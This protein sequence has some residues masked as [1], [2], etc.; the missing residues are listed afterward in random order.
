MNNDNNYR[1]HINGLKVCL[2]YGG[3]IEKM[4]S[5][6]EKAI[7]NITYFNRV[8]EGNA[9]YELQS[10]CTGHFWAIIPVE[11]NRKGIYY[12]LLHKYREQDCY[13]L[14]T[15]CNSVLDA[16]LE[17][18]SHDDY[19]MKRNSGFFEKVWKQYKEME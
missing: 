7:M 8:H 11:L 9:I 4:F 13:H 5:D 19:K 18:I 15:N 2:S 10:I 14:Q 12:M 1:K 6:K 3:G 17:I 16:V